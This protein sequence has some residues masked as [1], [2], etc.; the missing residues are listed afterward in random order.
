MVRAFHL[1][2]IISVE[3]KRWMQC[4]L[5]VGLNYLLVR[6]CVSVCVCAFVHAYVHECA[7][8]HVYTLCMH[9]YYIDLE[10]VFVLYLYV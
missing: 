5:K 1:L 6:V 4:H 2:G 9:A 7:C 8:V 3:R 10:F